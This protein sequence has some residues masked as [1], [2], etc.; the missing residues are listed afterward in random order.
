MDREKYF[1]ELRNSIFKSPNVYISLGTVILILSI[2]EIFIRLPLEKFFLLF[3]IPY[4]LII[5][6]DAMSFRIT[7]QYFPSERLFLLEEIVFIFVFI[8]YLIFSLLFSEN[9]VVAV[10][11]SISL[12]SFLRY[13]FLKPFLNVKEFA[14]AIIS[15]N[16]AFAT[17]ITYVFTGASLLYLIP[18]YAS[19]VMFYLSSRFFIFYLSREFRKEYNLDPVKYVGYFINYL[20]TQKTEDMI[21]LNNFLTLMYSLKELPLQVIAF[22][23]RGGG[24]K[25]LLVFPYVHP[26][27]FGE[28]GC[29][30]LPFRIA[31]RIK[32]TNNV[33]VFHTTSTHN[34]N[35]SGEDDI[36]KIA[37]AVSNSLKVMKFYDTGGPVHRYSG[38]ISARCQVLGDTLILSLIPDVTGFD[39]VSIET[40][41][42]L[43]RKLKS[44]RIRNVVVIDSH[45]NFNIDYKILREIDNDTM[46]G[47][48]ECI[49]DMSRNKLSVGFSR[50]EYGSGSTGPMGVQTLVIKTDKTY[51]YI[52]VDGNNIKSGLREKV[53][54]SLKGMVDDAEIYSTDNHIVNMNPKDLNPIGNKDDEERLMDAIKESLSRAMDDIEEVEIGTHT[55]KV[56]VKVGGKGYVE[57]VSEIVNKMVKRLKFSILIVIISFIIS[58]L[59]FSLSFLLI[60]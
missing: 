12:S 40:G 4:L 7:D 55:T 48:R 9:I 59:I 8:I 5:A 32:D 44:S 26:G 42:K 54:E 17:T 57:K 23:R 30:N 35:C 60:G 11:L 20:S 38:K 49:K 25:G 41:M 56:L 27:P 31:R 37:N 46:K 52:L 51:A 36:E 43:M 2:Y 50:I 14:L 15:M 34:E 33:M 3:V 53:L 18:F 16:Y 19:T 45:N 24:I 1:L 29:S 28:V 39:D 21:S 58:I 22:R 10:L 6:I 47:I 13:L